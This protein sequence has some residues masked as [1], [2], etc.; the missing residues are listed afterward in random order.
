MRISDWSSDVCSSDLHT[1]IRAEHAARTEP[2]FPDFEI[3]QVRAEIALQSRPAGPAEMLIVHPVLEVVAVA[4][5]QC[6]TQIVL[7]REVVGN[8]RGAHTQLGGNV[9]MTRAVDPALLHHR[10]PTAQNAP[11]RGGAPAR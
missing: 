3:A 9:L 10:L 1:E 11:T 6:D 4:T 5:P 2:A 7:G 8:G